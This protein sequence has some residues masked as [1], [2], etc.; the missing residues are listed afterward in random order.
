AVAI[1][2]DRE[3]TLSQY[4]KLPLGRPKLP[5]HAANIQRFE[6]GAFY[7]HVS[8][9]TIQ[10]FW[11]DFPESKMKQEGSLCCLCK[12]VFI[13]HAVTIPHKLGCISDYTSSIFC[14]GYYQ[15]STIFADT[16]S[17]SILKN[18]VTLFF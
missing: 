18:I 10:H 16:T 1:H 12:N 7:I 8:I 17:G 9:I 15:L 4:P 3:K 13:G 11:S 14:F 6:K 2:I 5:L